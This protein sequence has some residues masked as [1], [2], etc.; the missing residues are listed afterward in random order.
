MSRHVYIKNGEYC[1]IKNGEYCNVK[2][3]EYGNFALE[4]Q[5]LATGFVLVTYSMPNERCKDD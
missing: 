4:K 3:G 2:N 1:N 5:I